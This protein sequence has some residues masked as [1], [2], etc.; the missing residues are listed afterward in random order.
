MKLYVSC[1]MEGT[2]GVCSWRQ[3]DPENR[4]EYPI[5]RRYMTHE[6]R[7]AIDGAREGGATEFLVND[8][9]WS[10]RN[11]LWDELPAGVRVIAGAPKPHSMA[12]GLD[13]GSDGV[14]LTGYHAKSGA[15]DGVLAHTFSDETVYRV[16]INGVECSEALLVG[17]LAGANGIPV[18]LVT[19]DSTI[20]AETLRAFPWAV[21]VAVKESIGYYAANTLTP[22]AAQ[23][24]I[25]AGARDAMARVA[26]ARPFAFAGPV[27]MRLET[28]GAQHA[29]FIE[30]IPGFERLDGRTVRF[31][32]DDYPTVYRAYV[33]AVRLAGA[34]S[35]PA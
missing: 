18:L 31:S 8:S 30:L 35:A 23:I 24:A 19:G 28:T 16:T 2:A 5:Y 14:F 32:A 22:Q 4:D 3:C 20:V 29:D 12:E 21:G 11:L 27:E 9:H 25:R 6:V 15:R 10:M 26:A 33:A 13:G 34:A 17:A 7:A 1:D